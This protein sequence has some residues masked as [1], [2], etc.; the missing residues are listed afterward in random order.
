MPPRDVYKR[1]IQKN[2]ERCMANGRTLYGWNIVEGRYAI[3]EREA[4]VLRRM[5]NLLFS[6]NSVAE[7]VRA[8]D[9]ER[10]K[11]GAKFN[12]DTVTKLLK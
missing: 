7:I 2:A 9:A 3:N 10:S 12:Q 6:G 1:Q 11:R 5:K 4:A 8:V